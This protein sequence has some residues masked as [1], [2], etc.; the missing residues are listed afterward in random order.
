MTDQE[1]LKRI[2]DLQHG[3]AGDIGGLAFLR[4]LIE[5]RTR[6]KKQLQ[7]KT[8]SA[9]DRKRRL[10]EGGPLVSRSEVAV[11]LPVLVRHWR[12]VE[13]LFSQYAMIGNEAVDS[14]QCLREFIEGR[15]DLLDMVQRYGGRGELLH[16]LM[17]EVL[18]P[19][20]TLYGEAYGKQ[21]EDETWGEPFCYVCGGLPDMALLEGD[22]GKRY[23]R[24]GLCDT[25]WWYAKLKCP[26]C[27][28][29]DLEK[30]VTMTLESESLTML[31]GCKACNRYIKVVDTRGRDGALFPELEDLRTANLDALARGEGFRPY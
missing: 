24:C 8:I 31:N 29:E 13:K 10:S 17:L 18:K 26:Y 28:N 1:K 9:T 21:L 15:G 4:R 30:L 11:A 19:L 16:Y 27:G 12:E 23:L 3:S 7:I 2:L 6:L 5:L 22:G 20:Y 25:S 14:E